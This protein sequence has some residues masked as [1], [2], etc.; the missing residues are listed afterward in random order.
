MGAWVSRDEK[1]RLSASC[2]DEILKTQIEG[3]QDYRTDADLH[4]ACEPDAKKICKDVKPGEGRIQNCL[5]SSPPL[6]LPCWQILQYKGII[7][8]CLL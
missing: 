1:D 7:H 4:L 5:A 3:A 8:R 6:P 2:K